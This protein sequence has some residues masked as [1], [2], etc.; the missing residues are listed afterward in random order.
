MRRWLQTAV[1]VA[2]AVIALRSAA[3]LMPNI[4][5]EWRAWTVLR[6]ISSSAVLSQPPA[7]GS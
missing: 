3:R 2:V 7:E 5:T 1:I 6:Q 4:V